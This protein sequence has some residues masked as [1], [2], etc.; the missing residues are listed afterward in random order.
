MRLPD[1]FTGPPVWTQEKR[2]GVLIAGEREYKGAV[3]FEIRLWTGEGDKPTAKGVTLPCDAVA[4]LAEA[5]AAYTASRTP[6]SNG[7]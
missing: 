6:V 3:F 7:G 2:E 1:G 5:L 4:G